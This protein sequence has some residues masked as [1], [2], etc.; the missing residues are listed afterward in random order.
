V[1]Y[2]NEELF[3]VMAL[4][5]LVI[6]RSGSNSLYELILL[7][8]QH[9]LIPLTKKASRGDQIDNAKYFEEK[10]LSYVLQEEEL[11]KETLLAEIKA[12]LN[13]SESYQERLNNYY[14]P[15][16]TEKIVSILQNYL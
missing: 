16:G 2:L 6:S 12:I 14:C 5:D 4:A 8:K 11:S 15:N 1:E 9:I 3:D 13:N 7:K 10:G